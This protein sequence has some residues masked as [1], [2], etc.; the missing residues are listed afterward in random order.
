MSPKVVR[1]IFCYTNKP[2]RR[3]LYPFY[4]ACLL[5]LVCLVF[6]TYLLLEYYPHVNKVESHPYTAHGKPLDSLKTLNLPS[7]VIQGGVM[8]RH[9]RWD[10]TEIISIYGGVGLLIIFLAVMISV[11]LLFLIFWVDSIYNKIL[12]PYERIL[13]E[14]DRVL[15]GDKKGPLQTRK[16]DDKMFEELL[17]RIN[18]LIV[19][20]HPSG[21]WL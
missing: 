13:A 2:Q 8:N 19:R 9:I 17:K 21:R 3:L 16:G 18:V 6:F 10:F 12:G 1:D 14:L 20:K 4:T 5:I 7:P 15:S 11:I